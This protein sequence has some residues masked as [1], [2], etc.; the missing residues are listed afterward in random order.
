MSNGFSMN[1][2][3]DSI[4]CRLNQSEIERMALQLRQAGH[5]LVADPEA[6]DLVL[7]NTCSV[8]TAAAADSRGKIRSAH[9]KNNEAQIVLT[10]C[11]SDVEPENAASLPGVTKVVPNKNKDTLVPDMLGLPHETFRRITIPRQP[12]P[13]ARKR[14]R[15]FVKVQDG[16]NNHCTFCLATVARGAGLSQPIECIVAEIKS[17]IAGGVKE[18][19][20]TG[21]QLSAYGRDLADDIDL[22]YLLKTILK[23][24]DIP[25]IRL[26]SME[27]WELPQEFF[28]VM[29]DSR[30]CRQLHLPLQ[31]GCGRTL[32]RMGRPYQPEEY[33]HI[34]ADARETIPG[35]A[36]TTDIIVGFPGETDDEFM[37]SL[38]FINAM[39]FTKAHVFIYS[40]RPKTAASHLPNHVS[41]QIARKRSKKIRQLAE[42]SAHAFRSK[43]VGEVLTVL[44]ETATEQSSR[45][46]I[47]SGLTDNYIRVY[48]NSDKRLQNIL[49]DVRLTDV[50]YEAMRGQI[51]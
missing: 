1:V 40:P 38:E 27:P 17:A 32:R 26:S 25:R 22:A 2:F 11:W 50:E 43:F 4:G 49:T 3:L 18:V 45:N 19:V 7:I 37:E 10:G 35:L 14:T 39:A 31:S 13:G 47:V 20:L 48:A 8:T 16:C 33:A 36:I 42:D 12:I 29:Q 44:W 28:S 21:A 9:R 46:W 34:I 23:E 30:I 51:V 41:F 24:T 15:A 5:T 6:S